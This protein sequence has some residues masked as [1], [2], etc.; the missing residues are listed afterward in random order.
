M[1]VPDDRRTRQ[2]EKVRRRL[3]QMKWGMAL[4]ALLIVGAALFFG[5]AG[6]PGEEEEHFAGIFVGVMVLVIVVAF[7]L[8][9]FYRGRLTA[10]RHPLVQRKEDDS[11]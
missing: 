3:A 6:D 10:L 5:A 4:G 7:L 2:E 9:L 1:T 11:G 8:W